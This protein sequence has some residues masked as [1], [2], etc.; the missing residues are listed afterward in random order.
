MPIRLKDGDLELEFDTAD[1]AAAYRALVQK[2]RED[3]DPP[4]KVKPPKRPGGWNGFAADLRSR[5]DLQGKLM[6]LLLATVKSA[7]PQR[8]I[9]WQSV[10]DTLKI[11][12]RQKAYEV[13]AE[14]LT[15]LESYRISPRNVL[16]LTRD[17]NRLCPRKFL[18]EFP[19][20]WRAPDESA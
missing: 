11:A 7:S 15:L 20:D 6:R 12:N 3:S 17:N 16:V 9:D 18:L 5:T 1:E 4:Q 14:I 10:T 13:F 19:D 8:G 2:R